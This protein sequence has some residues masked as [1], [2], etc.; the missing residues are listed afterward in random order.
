M[1]KR[2]DIPWFLSVGLRGRV[3]EYRRARGILVKT[4]WNNMSFQRLEY[5]IKR[6]GVSRSRRVP[7]LGVCED[8][9]VGVKGDT[10][11]LASRAWHA[12]PR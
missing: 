3:E 9:Y 11:G 6:I 4:G 7:G 2:R 8:T 10:P 5:R 1:I 12:A